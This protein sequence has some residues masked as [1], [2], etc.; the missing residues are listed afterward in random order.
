MI[1]WIKCQDPD[2]KIPWCILA[3]DPN[4]NG[5]LSSESMAKLGFI[6]CSVDNRHYIKKAIRPCTHYKI[7][8][9]KGI[10]RKEAK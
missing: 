10:V 8:D 7:G 9:I 3:K 6:T 1:P 2:C 5:C 4:P